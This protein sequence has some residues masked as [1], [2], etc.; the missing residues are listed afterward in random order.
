MGRG[1]V[2]VW[3]GVIN[4]Y[5]QVHFTFDITNNHLIYHQNMHKVDKRIVVQVALYVPPFNNSE[6]CDCLS[7]VSLNRKKHVSAILPEL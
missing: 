4:I 5:Q 6:S 3:G 7:I 1:T 2:P